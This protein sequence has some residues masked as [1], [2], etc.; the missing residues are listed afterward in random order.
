VHTQRVVFPNIGLHPDPIVSMSPQK[1][2]PDLYDIDVAIFNLHQPSQCDS[3]EVLLTLFVHKETF[4][5]GP[6]LRYARQGDR[7]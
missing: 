3:L 5:Y 7:T 1:S 2:Q 4:W 6:S